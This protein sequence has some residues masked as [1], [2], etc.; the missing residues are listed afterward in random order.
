MPFIS[1]QMSNHQ[2]NLLQA[3]AS[4]TAQIYVLGGDAVNA[5]YFGSLAKQLKEIKRDPE[6]TFPGPMGEVVWPDNPV[7]TQVE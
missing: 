5:R 4:I 6:K 1:I 7:V 2:I 3:S